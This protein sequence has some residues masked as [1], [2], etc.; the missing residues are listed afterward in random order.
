VACESF[1]KCV[2]FIITS[3]GVL[4]DGRREEN[5]YLY[6]LAWNSPAT[7]DVKLFADRWEAVLV[8]PWQS[9]GFDNI[10]DKPFLAN[11]YRAREVSGLTGTKYSAWSPVR[12]GSFFQPERFGI[13]NWEK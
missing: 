2:Q 5:G 12:R 9:F 10:P 11:I 8:M 4:W 3:G 6:D 13:F 1:G 7:L